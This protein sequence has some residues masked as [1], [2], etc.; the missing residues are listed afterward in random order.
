M[1]AETG[2]APV[3]RML[4]VFLAIAAAVL[5]CDLATKWAAFKYLD[6][7][8]R[9]PVI[10]GLFN[11]TRSENTGAVF[12]IGKGQREFFIVF[13]FAALIG[14]SWAQWAHGRSSLLLTCGLG[15]L[16]GGALGNLYDRIAFGKVRDFIDVYWGEWHWPTFNVAD[17][18][19]VVGCGLLLLYSLRMPPKGKAASSSR[20]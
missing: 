12:G 8:L 5:F 13:S 6:P 1:T 7:D 3:W 4:A 18:A 11:L 14:I 2:R 9:Y 16:A 17:T 19:I 15:L 20:S 10:P